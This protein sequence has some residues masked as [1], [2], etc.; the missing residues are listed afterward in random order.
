[1]RLVLEEDAPKL[2]VSP[3]GLRLFRIFGLGREDSV[4][5]RINVVAMSV[6][7]VRNVLAYAWRQLEQS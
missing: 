3:M 6:F 5:H 1:M 2:S 7:T 4:E